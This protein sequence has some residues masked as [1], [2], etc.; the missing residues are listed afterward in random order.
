MRNGIENKYAQQ[1]SN[2]K[3]NRENSTILRWFEKLPYTHHLQVFTL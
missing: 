1:I 3:N 2:N